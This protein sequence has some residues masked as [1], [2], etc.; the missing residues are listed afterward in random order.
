PHFRF[1]YEGFNE[2]VCKPCPSWLRKRCN[3]TSSL[4]GDRPQH[5]ATAELEYFRRFTQLVERERWQAD[6][7][8]AELLDD[9]RTEMRKRNFRA[10]VNVRVVVGSEPFTFAFEE[11][12][13]DLDVGDAVLI[14]SGNISSTPNFHGY[15]REIQSG[16][17]RVSIPLKNLQPSVF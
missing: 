15:V 11:N 2:E 7:A 6:Q 16:S 13:S 5:A 14:H 1:R 3:E 17:L 8:V 9:G 4:F 10:L 12:T